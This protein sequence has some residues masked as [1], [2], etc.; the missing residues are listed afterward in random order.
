M[1]D[2][3]IPPHSEIAEQSLLGSLMLSQD[4]FDEIAGS[5]EAEQFYSQGNA[6]VFRVISTMHLATKVI[7]VF[8]VAEELDKRGKLEDIGGVGYLVSLA[9]N[10][11][12]AANIRAY[13]GIVREHW[14]ASKLIETAYGIEAMILD[15]TP[16]REALDRASAMLSEISET[17]SA[18]EPT[19]IGESLV[20]FISL[21]DEAFNSKD[22]FIGLETGLRDLDKRLGGLKTGNLIIVAGRPGMGKTSLA[23]QIGHHVADTKAPVL[24]LSMEMSKIELVA[25]ETARIG[26]LSVEDVL[27]GNLDENGWASLTHA[28]S[29][30]QTLP[31][32]IDESG[33]LSLTEVR[34]KARKAKRKHGIGLLIVDYLQL[35][36][37]EHGDNREQQVSEISRGLK[38]LAKEIEIPVIA[39]SQLSRKCEERGNKRPIMSDLRES[40]S[41]EQDADMILFVY[42]DEIY[43]PESP[44]AGIAEII[45]GKR[46]MGAPGTVYT[47]F[48]GPSTAFKDFYG[49]V[50]SHTAKPKRMR[51]ME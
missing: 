27:K 19:M 16:V 17:R 12:S 10:T 4:A 49:P 13:A 5:I 39:L 26:S 36:R 25:R 22:G 43:N 23:M 32:V 11:P 24:V 47:I 33:G 2:L 31:M 29:K 51:G 48:D 18:N 20:R 40:G 45:I 1:N 44:D 8:T 38:S 28:T 50:P 35:M 42:R 21:V 6:D 46:R 41:I 34:A 9:Q 3:R 7:D 14:Q 30:L 37:G 15:K